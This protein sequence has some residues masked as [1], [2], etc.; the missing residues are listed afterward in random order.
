MNNTINIGPHY[1]I[2]LISD[3]NTEG[4]TGTTRSLLSCLSILLRA[5][6]ADAWT[7]ASGIGATQ[8][9]FDSILSFC[10]DPKPRIR[11]A[12][13]QTIISVL[14]GSEMMK[15]SIDEDAGV[16]NDNV[17]E[18]NSHQDTIPPYHPAAI[19]ASK[20]CQSQIEK[21]AVGGSSSDGASRAVLH[22]LSLL[23]EII[24]IFPK[25]HVKSSCETVLKVMTSGDVF[26]VSSGMQ[27]LYGLFNSRPSISSLPSDLNAKII[28]SL[29][30]YQPSINDAQPTVAW[31][32]VQQEALI[33]LSH[34]DINLCMKH[35]PKFVSSAARCWTS[36][37]ST[38][39]TA[40]TT[41]IKAVCMECIKP[42]VEDL[43][44]ETDM[45]SELKKIFSSLEEGLKYQY[46]SAWAQVLHLLAAFIDVTGHT[47]C[48]EFMG[49]CLRTFSDLRASQNFRFTNELDYV[50]GKALRKMGPERVLH[51]IPLN[52]TGKEND[53]LRSWMLPIMRENIQNT[54]LAFFIS[55]FLPMQQACKNFALQAEKE[56]NV[57]LNK[58][59]EILFTQIWALLPGFCNNPTDLKDAFT[60]PFAKILGDYLSLKELR[61]DILSALRQIILKTTHD[62][63]NKIAIQK[64]AKNYLPILFNLYTT[65]PSG[66]E[67]TGQ[68][69]SIFETAKLFFTISDEALLKDLFD[70][71][72]NEYKTSSDEFRVD[73]CLDLLQGMLPYQEQDRITYLYSIC[74][75]N[76]TGTE[77]KKQKKAYRVL[78]E[79]FRSNTEACR[80][81]VKNN[82]EEIQKIF[83]EAL[84]KA[85]PSSQAYRLRCLINIV[86]NLED[87]HTEFAYK[88][89][90]ETVLCIKATNEKAR[91]SSYSL[92]IVICEALQRWQKSTKSMDTIVKD[93]LKE[94]FAGLAGNPTVVHCTLLAITR[95]YYEFKDVFPEDVTE[96][97]VNNVCLLLTSHAKEVVG[98]AISFLRVFVTTD[99]VLKTAKYV[100][101]IVGAMVKMPEACRRHFRLKSRYLLDRLIR[102]FGYDLITAIIPKDDLVMQKRMKNIRYKSVIILCIKGYHIH[103]SNIL[104]VSS[105][106]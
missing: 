46:H 9:V 102:K 15:V 73:A 64:K 3:G 19:N 22:V 16:P 70:K 55:H 51:Y 75:S 5:Q 8:R 50:V 32:T 105:R 6:S 35:L 25:S 71:A 62:P 33:N 58:S 41:A 57:A 42:H 91:S 48:N 61:F 34:N 85:N 2:F 80:N 81:F 93:F 29:Y 60:G 65:K 18:S 7:Q 28:N 87:D 90:P 20:Y 47:K 95:I 106:D 17:L 27:V 83:L 101:N 88:I 78:E 103:F 53:F 96:M 36:D 77:S 98:A 52:I 94:I 92:L 86:R 69:Q 89:V 23:K 13:H 1:I 12:A 74:A 37:K 97:L 82:L 31:L 30:N 21:Y 84:S 72:L 66:S 10:L 39:V 54:K 45:F 68:R 26:T 44:E 49:N 63:D 14:K 38:V 76:V 43:V 104:T 4:G 99:S 56:S 79:L 11:K 67:E 24:S 59:Y 100:E 40:A